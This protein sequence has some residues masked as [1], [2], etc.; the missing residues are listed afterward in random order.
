[1]KKKARRKIIIRPL[2]EK[3]P[4]CMDKTLP[5]LKKVDILGKFLTDRARIMSR[6]RSGVCTKHQK[7]LSA[8]IK[9]ARFLALLTVV[10]R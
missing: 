6:E 3:C 5:S 2:H 7:M 8:E 4:F 9:K 1:M 10:E